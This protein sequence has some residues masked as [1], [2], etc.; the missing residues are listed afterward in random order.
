MVRGPKE[1][2]NASSKDF[3]RH[4]RIAYGVPYPQNSAV[5]FYQQELSPA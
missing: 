1:I 4:N 5:I 2:Y 3:I